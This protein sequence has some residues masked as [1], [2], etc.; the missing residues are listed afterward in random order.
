MQ[1][2]KDATESSED[3]REKGKGSGGGL[4]ITNHNDLKNM[5]LG[6][7]AVDG[8]WTTQWTPAV[9]KNFCTTTNTYAISNVAEA[10]CFYPHT[11]VTS[12]CDCRTC[13]ARCN[14]HDGTPFSL[15]P[16]DIGLC[17]EGSAMLGWK[18]GRWTWD[19]KKGKQSGCVN[20]FYQV[21]CWYLRG[22]V[23]FMEL[24]SRTYVD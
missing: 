14:D 15:K 19:E 16:P 22:K 6:W 17:R 18:F 13:S 11:V 1:R 9:S 21:L 2:Y 23:F 8:K 5:M 7:N 4:L 10:L 24:P 20:I 3:E 12:F